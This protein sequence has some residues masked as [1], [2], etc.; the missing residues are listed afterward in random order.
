MVQT[1]RRAVFISMSYFDS[2][3]KMSP[4]TTAA[5]QAMNN[6]MTNQVAG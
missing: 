3:F 4:V 6:M 5:T 1:H 2:E